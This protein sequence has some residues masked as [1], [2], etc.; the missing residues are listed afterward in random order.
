M[1][2][3]L[4]R[5]RGVHA[6]VLV[7]CY[8]RVQMVSLWAGAYGGG[9]SHW[10][11]SQGL[12][13]YLSATTTYKSGASFYLCRS[14]ITTTGSIQTP[15]WCDGYSGFS[16][17]YVTLER[18]G[19]NTRLVLQEVRVWRGGEGCASVQACLLGWQGQQPH[20][21]AA[22]RWSDQLPGAT[23]C[24]NGT[25]PLCGSVARA[26]HISASACP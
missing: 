8:S 2:T 16:A 21:C 9:N 18:I 22:V 3:E 17:E 11:F 7:M 26:V 14:G 6:G 23:A 15:V 19:T 4:V 20:S 25:M 5:C 10:I 1:R 24:G 13:L 12:S